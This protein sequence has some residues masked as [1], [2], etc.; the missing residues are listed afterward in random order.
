MNKRCQTCRESKPTD[1][2]YRRAKSA[3]GLQEVCKSCQHSYRNSWAEANPEKRSAQSKRYRESNLEKVNARFAK[4]KANNPDYESK[5]Y[6]KDPARFA[7]RLRQFR[8][9]N[10]DACPRYIARRKTAKLRATP[11]WANPDAIAAYYKTAAHRTAE[12]GVPWQV[13]HI[14]PLV[15]KKVCGLHVEHNLC[16]ITASENH[17]KSNRVWP[18]MPT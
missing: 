16:V 11:A 5:R 6:R 9:K 4:W 15:S 1:E 3:D 12:S 17:K 7:E 18:D 10:P 2:F 8:L 14:V 13:D